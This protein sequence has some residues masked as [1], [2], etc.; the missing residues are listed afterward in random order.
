[1]YDK[2][3]CL[4]ALSIS[5]TSHY[6]IDCYRKVEVYPTSYEHKH[7]LL[8]VGHEGLVKGFLIENGRAKELWMMRLAIGSRVEAVVVKGMENVHS[9]VKYQSKHF[10][11]FQ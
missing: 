1:M 11:T 6:S 5:Q 7:Y 4:L 9:Q 10:L 8:S 3:I 2:N